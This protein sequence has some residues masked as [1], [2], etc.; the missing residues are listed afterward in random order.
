MKYVGT[1][2]LACLALSLAACGGSHLS[3]DLP[4]GEETHR[5]EFVHS[6]A[7]QHPL[8]RIS[9]GIPPYESSIEG[10][11]DWVTLFP[12]QGVLAGV[13]PVEDHSKTYFCTYRITE[14]D[15]GFRPARTVSYGL[16]LVVV[17]FDPEESDWRF[18]TRTV[19][20]TGGPCVFPGDPAIPVATLPVAHAGEGFARYALPG[21]PRSPQPGFNL[22]FD[23]S[24]REL[25]YTNPIAPPVLGTP[26]TY[27]YLVGTEASVDAE[28]ADDALC[29]DVR[30]DSGADFCP[31]EDSDDDGDDD[32]DDDSADPPRQP[33]QY[34]HIHLQ[35]RDDA[36]WDENA[37]RYRCPDTT[38]LPPPGTG[39]QGSSSNP[40]HEALGPVH[41]RR[42]S[43][44]AHAAVRD[45]VLGW[46]P[47][48]EQVTFAIAP[49]GRSRVA[50][51]SE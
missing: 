11:P 39:A 51:G 44:V 50:L 33:E 15:P 37:E 13:A 38:A 14:S 42:A 27:L 3:V 22:S 29:L 34:V 9:G 4:E 28:N 26:N 46:S 18:R 19:A 49:R 47:R 40:V 12:D 6:R 5:L 20:E 8:P 7:V 21:V 17:E 36:F 25:T 32:S 2:I 30:V 1:I 24:I 10:C 48:A 31:G 41:A 43:A 23:P 35:V 45:R 16:R